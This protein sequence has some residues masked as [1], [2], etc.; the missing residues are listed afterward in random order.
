MKVPAEDSL[1]SVH[2]AKPTAYDTF[3]RTAFSGLK[4]EGPDP[5]PYQ[6]RLA[7]SS[8]LP[9]ILQIPTGA[10]K[11]AAVILAWLWRRRF[12]ADERIRQRTPRRLVYCLPMR[13]LVEQTAERAH[14][15]LRHLELTEEAGEENPIGLYTLMGGELEERWTVEPERDAILVGTQDMLLSRAL[16]RGYAASRFRWPIEFGLLNNDCQWVFDETQLMGVGRSTSAQLD[17]FR[18][19]LG[20]YGRCRSLWMSA[21]LQPEDLSTVDFAGHIE[22]LRSDQ[23][24]SED[25]ERPALATRLHASKVLHSTDLQAATAKTRQ[26]KYRRDLGELVLDRHQ[27]GTQ[28]LVVM[29]RVDRA[30]GLYER[31][32]SQGVHPAADDIG[33]DEDSSAVRGL[34]AHSRFRGTERRRLNERLQ[35][36]VDEDGPG[37]IVVATQVVEAGVDLS[38]RVLFTELAPWPSLVQR[39]GRCNRYGEHPEAEVY[40]MGLEDGAEAPYE[41]DPIATAREQLESFSGESVAPAHLEVQALPIAFPVLRKRDLFEFFDTEPDLSGNDVDVSPYIREHEERDVRVFW[42][43]WTSHDPP[44]SDLPRPSYEELCSV[45]IGSLREVLKSA[46]NGWK[47]DHLDGE[48]RRLRRNELRP[49]QVVLLRSSAGHYSTERGWNPDADEPV[50]VVSNDPSGTGSEATGEDRGAQGSW[51][52]LADHSAAVSAEVDQ[53]LETVG[54]LKIPERIQNQL[55]TA[56]RYHDL[57][58]AH[59]VFQDALFGNGNAPPSDDVLWAKGPGWTP[60]ERPHFRHELASALAMLAQPEVL[61]ESLQEEGFLIPYLVAAHHGKVRLAIRALPGEEAPDAPGA[62]PDT[63]FA[64]GIWEGDELPEVDLGD[65][66]TFPGAILDLHPMEMGRSNSGEP[67]WLERSLRLVKDDDL[68]PFRLGFLEALLRMADWRVSARGGTGGE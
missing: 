65:G 5:Y 27:E 32:R 57:G 28:T 14:E 38:C 29:N 49:G 60:Y 51:E 39:F 40:W 61:E 47:W 31:L 54:A 43:D 23:L 6:R 10:G 16:N 13:V 59:P 15:Y 21:T 64:R 34:L 42:R 67:S 41:A 26:R 2:M 56:A 20:S 35:E 12:H 63:R 48:W 53:I 66:Q 33:G 52:T 18:R 62:N 45:P 55:R 30:V 68:G 58:K 3:F 9:D 1:F 11:T 50:P 25:I 24:T 36:P 37:R 19:R 46:T 44:P 7:E 22:T 8:E 4:T 17:A